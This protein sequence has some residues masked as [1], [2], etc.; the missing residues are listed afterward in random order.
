MPS[1]P[2]LNSKLGALREFVGR[3]SAL[4]SETNPTTER[5][6]ASSLGIARVCR[7]FSCGKDACRQGWSR[8]IEIARQQD[9][10]GDFCV[11]NI[12]AA[13]FPPAPRL[14]RRRMFR[15]EA[16]GRGGE[17]EI[18]RV[19]CFAAAMLPLERYV[20]E[21]GFWTASHLRPGWRL[22]ERALSPHLNGC[23]VRKPAQN[24]SVQTP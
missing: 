8:T 9:L 1:E 2:L 14:R 21:A 10:V 24:C 6:A 16:N 17:G 4:S 11:A 5:W 19:N 3:P 15:Q 13:S 12:R 7:Q 23:G 22:L 20:S 18:G